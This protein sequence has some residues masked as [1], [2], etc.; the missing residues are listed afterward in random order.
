MKESLKSCSTA[1]DRRYSL[2]YIMIIFFLFEKMDEN[3]ENFPILRK[4]RVSVIKFN[5]SI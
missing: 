3:K 5:Q 4:S 2:I 1:C